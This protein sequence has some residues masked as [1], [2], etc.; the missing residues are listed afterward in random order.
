MSGQPGNA[1]F[2]VDMIT[3]WVTGMTGLAGA[4]VALSSGLGSSSSTWK[5]D[6][7]IKEE[8][9]V[10]PVIFRIALAVTIILSGA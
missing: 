2:F 3:D 6:E 9:V 4:W 8:G 1:L 10:I 5:E 7:R